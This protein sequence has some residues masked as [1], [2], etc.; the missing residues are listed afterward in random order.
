MASTPVKLREPADLQASD[1]PVERCELSVQG[2]SCASCAV[3]I[4]RTLSRKPGVS[5]ARVNFASHGA[6]VAYDPGVV[7]LSELVAAVDKLGYRAAR[8]ETSS[9]DEDE[10]TRMG[11]QRGWLRRV[12]LSAPLAVAVLVLVY[13]FGDESW[14]H[15]LAFALTLPIQFVAGWPILLSGLAR[16]RRLTANMDTLIAMGTLTAFGFSTVRLL[17]GGDLFFDTAA[18]IM[19]FIVLGRFFEARATSRASGA[20]KK[21]LE[22]GA[23][24]ARVIVDGQERMVPVEEVEVGALVRVKPGEKFPVDAEV[25]DGRATV[26]E[27]MLTG[28]SL[29]VEKSPGAIVA[30]A[31]VNLDGALTVRTTAVGRDTALAQI[32]ELV[33]SAQ[34]S[35]APVQRLADRVARAFVPIVLAL[36][37]ATFLGWWLL[38]GSA[39]GG[40]VAAVAVLIIAC[41]CA[42]GLATPTAIMVGTGRGAALGVLIEGG[43]VLETS[44]RVDTVVFD[45]TGTLTEGKMGL[46]EHA[47]A[48]SDEQ[49]VLARA[50]AVEASSEHPIAAAILAGAREQHLGVPAA[51]EFF[52]RTGH[53]VTAIVNGVP[54]TVGRRK[55]MAEAA[56]ALPPALEETAGGWEA[57]GLTAVFVGWEGQVRGALAVGDTLKPDAA[58]AVRA[59]HELGV[60]VAL[61]TGDNAETAQAIAAEVGIDRVIAEVLPEDKVNEVRRLQAQGRVVAMVG[62]GI[63][64]APALVQAELGI[65]I[66]TGTD[67]AI[68]SSDIILMS[69][70]PRGVATALALSRRTLRTIRQNLGW[71]FSYNLAALPL[72]A[73]GV[74][75]PIAAGAIMAFSSVSVVTNSLRLFRFD[76]GEDPGPANPA[77]G[78][79]GSAT[80]GRRLSSRGAR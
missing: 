61:L 51:S 49:T 16:A 12:A 10:R 11:E 46:R 36:A 48:A 25:V 22:L 24:E 37:G 78:S 53:G 64:D 5:E 45:K 54:V 34:E 32:V 56:L 60:D 38:G 58:T 74:L 29:P 44:R 19:T 4:E 30:G 62:D 9:A 50:A 65:A 66:G 72:A 28:E 43:D 18:V 73:L 39:L 79:A 77:A 71:A 68:E 2:M 69:G 67:V 3:R 80:G 75:P 33:Q 15:W 17:T 59:L 1:Q 70:D 31:T 23:D 52:S 21:L 13:G 42:M 26:D 57:R 63:N 76:R 41:P 40:M 55:L 7:D 35:K 14:A 20:I 6:R 8:L 47:A 27:S